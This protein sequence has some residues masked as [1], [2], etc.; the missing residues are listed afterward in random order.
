MELLRAV[1][2]LRKVEKYIDPQTEKEK[3]AIISTTN[4][5]DGEVEVDAEAEA[6]IDALFDEFY[7]M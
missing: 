7:G 5:I 2:Q 6:E 3:K 4:E 1:I